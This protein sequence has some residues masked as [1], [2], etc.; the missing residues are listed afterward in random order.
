MSAVPIAKQAS[1]TPSHLPNQACLCLAPLPCGEVTAKTVYFV[2]LLSETGVVGIDTKCASVCSSSNQL[3]GEP[4]AV[5]AAVCANPYRQGNK[6]DPSSAE[7]ATAARAV[8]IAHT[9]C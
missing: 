4:A 7:T 1:Q 6:L 2:G 8:A 3:G 5:S 9:A